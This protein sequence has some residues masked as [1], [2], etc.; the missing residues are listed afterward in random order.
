M[1]GISSIASSE[2]GVDDLPLSP[3]QRGLLAEAVI[4]ARLKRERLLLSHS[5]FKSIAA[6]ARKAMTRALATGKE[7][8]VACGLLKSPSWV[9][10]FGEQRPGWAAPGVRFGN[11]KPDLIRFMRKEKGGEGEVQ[12][13]V[14]EV[15]YS[16]SDRDIVSPSPAELLLR[17]QNEVV[18]DLRQLQGSSYLL[19]VL[20]RTEAALAHHSNPQTT[21][22]SASSSPP[23]LSYPLPTKSPSSSPAILGSQST[24]PS[25]RTSPLSSTTSST[26]CRRG[27]MPSR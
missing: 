7:V 17:V 16:G 23:S 26:C 13:E 25:E 18:P 24:S 14:I 1:G 27:C 21:S 11:F 19:F 4:K 8:Y 15:K 5:N 10:E 20:A 2:Q 12:W 6:V 9:R 3:I 22:L